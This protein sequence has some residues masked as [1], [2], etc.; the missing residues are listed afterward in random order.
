MILMD[1]LSVVEKRTTEKK[2]FAVQLVESA[3]LQSITAWSGVSV[4][5]PGGD[6]E[7]DKDEK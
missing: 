2:T 4:R 3:V 7:D 5:S 6:K 1:S